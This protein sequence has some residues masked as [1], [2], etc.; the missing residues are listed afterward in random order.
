MES[1]HLLSTCVL[2]C[3]SIV[4]QPIS[5]GSNT[6]PYL[7]VSLSSVGHLLLHSPIAQMICIIVL[8]MPVSRLSSMCQCVFL[9]VS[10]DA[11][12]I[13]CYDN[14]IAVVSASISLLVCY[15]S[16]E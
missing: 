2:S 4:R 12:V 3:T 5:D 10:D 7:T 15:R 11:D 13:R 6:L 14:A 8:L 1:R 9:T 16:G